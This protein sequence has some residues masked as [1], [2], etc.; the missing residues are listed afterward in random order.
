MYLINIRREI[1][2]GG[3]EVTGILEVLQ[4]LCGEDCVGASLTLF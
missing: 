1:F 2:W 4:S 3:C